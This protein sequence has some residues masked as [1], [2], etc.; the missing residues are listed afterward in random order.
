LIPDNAI[1][2]EIKHTGAS[3]RSILISN[4]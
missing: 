2:I 3:E 4:R 1:K